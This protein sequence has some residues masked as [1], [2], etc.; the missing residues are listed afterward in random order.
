MSKWQ[1]IESAPKDGTRIRVYEPLAVPHLA[2]CFF[3]R[4]KGN[5]W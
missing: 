2:V 1:P 5:E 4:F 3:D